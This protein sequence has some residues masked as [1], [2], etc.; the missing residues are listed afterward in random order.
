MLRCFLFLLLSSALLHPQTPGNSSRLAGCYQVTSLTWTPD[1]SD[2]HL[3]P[4]EFELSNDP[5]GDGMFRMKGLP[6]VKNNPIE[7]GWWW[8]PKGASKVRVDWSS[9]LGGIHGTLKRSR[10]G[11]LHGK[12]KEWCDSRCGWKRRTGQIR[13]QPIAC[14]P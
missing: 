12:I 11:D 10:N 13:V 4:K 5:R 1:G 8:K 9:G 7:R 6:L 14:T 3:I 2:I